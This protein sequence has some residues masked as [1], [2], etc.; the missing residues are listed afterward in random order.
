[1]D[2]FPEK[3]HDLLPPDK[4]EFSGDG[5]GSAPPANMPA[6]P[7][8]AEYYDYMMGML[9]SDLDRC[10]D[11]LRRAED[12]LQEERNQHSTATQMK[13][14]EYRTE[15]SKLDRE[16]H[17]LEMSSMLENGKKD[18]KIN[19]LQ[20]E[21]SHTTNNPDASSLEKFFQFVERVGPSVIDRFAQNPAAT[22]PQKEIHYSPVNETPVQDPTET[23]ARPPAD[24]ALAHFLN[25]I[26][27]SVT[28][29]LAQTQNL[30][31]GESIDT[32]EMAQYYANQYSAL[33]RKPVLEEW[34]R[35]VTKIIEDAGELKTMASDIGTVIGRVTIDLPALTNLL[36]N[37]PPGVAASMIA[38]N[39]DKQAL[40]YLK[41]VIIATQAVWSS[42]S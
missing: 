38:S 2:D 10:R 23:P 9:R 3:G 4:R 1:M 8:G 42:S 17:V 37:V 14:E 25:E 7:S 15:I 22:D 36:S 26:Y 34:K 31:D 20:F 28:E 13:A 30:K 16:I 18:Q 24:E 35:L 11:Q 19:Q 5:G 32:A 41:E 6:P 40:A 29:L 27:S 12:A 21:L 39:G 33:E